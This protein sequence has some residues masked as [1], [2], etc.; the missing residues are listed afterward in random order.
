MMIAFLPSY[1]LKTKDR[2]MKNWKKQ[3]KKKG[4]GRSGMRRYFN[5]KII[6]MQR[7]YLI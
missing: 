4:E 1:H 3:R 6:N 7:E 2:E 5:N